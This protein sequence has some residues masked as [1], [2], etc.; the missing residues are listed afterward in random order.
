MSD[1]A[2][3]NVLSTAVDALHAATAWWVDALKDSINAKNVADH[4]NTL[5]LLLRRI[6]SEDQLYTSQL[7]RFGERLH[8]VLVIDISRE[9]VTLTVVNGEPCTTLRECAHYAGLHG[10]VF[11]WPNNVAMTIRSNAVMVERNGRP[12]VIWLPKVR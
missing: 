7:H 4:A 10:R 8:G 2:T 11:D 3:S 9:P 6:L 1:A 5:D 12:D